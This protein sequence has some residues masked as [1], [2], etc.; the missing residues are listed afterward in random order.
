MPLYRH[1]LWPFAIVYGI[2][3]IIR[4]YLFRFGIFPS[5]EFDTPVI[6]VGNLEM[7]GTGKSQVVRYIVR[8]LVSKGKNVTVISRGYG[9]TTSGF[10][11]VEVDSIAKDVGDEPLELKR[12]FPTVPVAVCEKRAHGIEKLLQVNPKPDFVVMDDGF[13]HRWVRP[14]L[15]VLV[16]SAH[17]PYIN[18][19]LFP[20]GTLREPGLMASLCDFMVF[21]G[22]AESA[23][24]AIAEVEK[25]FHMKSVVGD[26]VHVSGDEC[27]W[28]LPYSAVLFSGI[29]NAERFDSMMRL[30]VEVLEHIRFRD[31]HNYTLSDMKRLRKKIDSFGTAVQVVF[32]TEKDAVR[33]INTPL[34]DE[35]GKIPVYY[36]PI[37][38]DVLFNKKKKFDKLIVEHGKHA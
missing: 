17:F 27:E 18:N 37:D 31:H 32:T 29:A 33:L 16:S 19:C 30:N 6:C 12:R 38:Q 7:G 36:L 15:T 20:V 5:K 10:R 26:L 2:V 4:Y 35:L 9:R 14:S 34:L 25:V 23:N 28:K 3:V 8:L 24:P 13:Q 1:L 21:T 11:M 22:V